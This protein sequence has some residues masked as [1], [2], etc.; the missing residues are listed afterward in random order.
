MKTL[1]YRG[2]GK[3]PRKAPFVKSDA[4]REL[5]SL[6]NQEAKDRHPNM[7]PEWLAPRKF[8][9]DTAN[10]LTKCVTEYIRLSDGFASRINNQG[11]YR[12]KL[13]RY[14]PS[15][16]RKGLSDVM[17]TYEGNSLH[18]EVKVGHDRQS[19]N[20]RLIELE[21]IKSGGYY[22]I[23]RTFTDFKKWFDGL[24]FR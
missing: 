7:R 9:D 20:Q 16:S 12:A 2:I 6:A 17:A 8:R 5:E 21:V 23:A 11:T 22:F 4:V 1:V 13:G 3:H 19:E 14:T 15:T 10:S 18:I 24:N